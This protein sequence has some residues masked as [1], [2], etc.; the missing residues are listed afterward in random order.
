[1]IIA[2]C[3]L[4]LTLI[5]P[6][7]A[8]WIVRESD[9]SS[10]S[11]L[12]ELKEAIRTS[13]S[14]RHVKVM[15]GS[16][17]TTSLVVGTPRTTSYL[18]VDAEPGRRDDD[19]DAL[20]PQLARA[21]LDFRPDLFGKQVLIIQVERRFDLGLASWSRSRREAHDAAAWRDKLRRLSIP[22]DKT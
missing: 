14:L 6:A 3:W 19:L 4:A 17:T 22:S 2:G 7:T 8:I 11:P 15:V 20:L 21:V 1:M 13:L 10:L 5:V 16:M 9:L 18:L 12:A